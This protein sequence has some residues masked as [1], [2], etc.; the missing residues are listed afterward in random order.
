MNTPHARNRRNV[1]ALGLGALIALSSACSEQ[2]RED[3]PPGAMPIPL[4]SSVREFNHRQAT[5]GRADSYVF[6]RY[7]WALETA[8]L[9]DWGRRHLSRVL[10]TV[11]RESFPVIIES[12]GDERL[13]DARRRVIIAALAQHE[14]DY[15]ERRVVV[16]HPNA[17]DISGDEGVILQQQFLQNAQQNTQLRSNVSGGSN[18]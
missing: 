2:R 10:S 9:T 14:L 7:E 5:K 6:Y 15:P 16:A 1:A 17:L 18:R 11:H 12:S 3:I 8:Q 4:G 13:D